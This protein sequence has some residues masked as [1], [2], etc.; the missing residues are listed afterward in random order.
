MLWMPQLQ[1]ELIQ[2]RTN[3]GTMSSSTNKNYHGSG[4]CRDNT[5]DHL[6]NEAL[7]IAPHRN[8][9]HQDLATS[10]LCPLP[11]RVADKVL[12][13]ARAEVPVLAEVAVLA[14]VPVLGRRNGCM[15]RQY[16]RKNQRRCHSQSESPRMP[17]V[18]K[19]PAA[20]HSM[21]GPLRGCSSRE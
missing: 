1:I 11:S 20:Q 3:S 15:S 8:N 17:Q 7:R 4:Q 16:S 18:R 19:L 21:L 6:L 13:E 5:R 10:A 9:S 12:E 2:L 14:E